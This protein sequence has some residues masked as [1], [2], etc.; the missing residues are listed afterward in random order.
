[1]D[2]GNTWNVLSDTLP[3]IGVSEIFIPNDYETSK[4]IYIATGDRDSGDN[5]SIGVLKSTDDGKTWEDVSDQIV[6]PAGTRHGTALSV[7]KKV[8]D[9]LRRLD[10]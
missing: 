5:Y 3:L 8:V 4:T 10:E 7:D 1:M 6:F 2:G 9:N